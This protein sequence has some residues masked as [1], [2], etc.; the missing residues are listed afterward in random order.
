MDIKR[1]VVGGWGV[2]CYLIISGNELVVID[3]GDETEKIV[4]EIEKLGKMDCKYILLTH[5]HF[6]HV[7]AV[8]DLRK[9][10]G[11]KVVID[12]EDEDISGMNLQIGVQLPDVD[13]DI[14]VKDKDNLDLAGQ[15]IRVIG[16]PG[17]TKGSVSYLI[18]GN[19][20][21]GD[22][23][24]RHT[25]GRT[26]LPG[27]SDR[28]IKNSLKNLLELDGKIKVYPGHGDE[29]TIQEERKHYAHKE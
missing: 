2:N 4:S 16:T 3:P 21:S 9:K 6:D 8:S 28:E 19:L 15:R 14:I 1:I 22:M 25:H 5:A 18:D 24:F 23:L 27:G 26:D 12:K 11:F 10:Y 20:F 29:T 13:T 17:H 7:G